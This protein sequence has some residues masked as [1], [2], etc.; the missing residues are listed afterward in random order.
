MSSFFLVIPHGICTP[1]CGVENVLQLVVELLVPLVRSL[2]AAVAAS[3]F[4][5]AL[6]TQRQSSHQQAELPSV[7]WNLLATALGSFNLREFFFEFFCD[8]LSQKAV[9]ALLP[10]DGVRMFFLGFF[11]SLIS[12]FFATLCL[13]WQ[14]LRAQNASCRRIF[15]SAMRRFDLTAF[16]FAF[17]LEKCLAFLFPF[18]VF[19]F[20][21]ILEKCLAFLFPLAVLF[22]FACLPLPFFL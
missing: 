1:F 4:V 22:A 15:K 10:A 5:H 18:A 7:F 16:C 6:R 20:A 17:V 9:E 13:S 3:L 21:F 12:S 11:L 8:F 14:N 19:C 2:V